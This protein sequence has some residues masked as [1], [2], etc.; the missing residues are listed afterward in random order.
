MDWNDLRYFLAVARSGSLTRAARELC[1]E[2]ATVSRR[3]GALEADLRA[4]LF[5]RGPA[6]LTLTPAGASLL[7]FVDAIAAQIAALERSV[8]GADAKV[9]GTVRLTIP[10]SGNAYFME[11]LAE[12]RGRHPELVIELLSENRTLDL[13]RGEA[14]VAVRFSDNLD[15]ELI[16]RKAGTAGWSLYAS[17]AYLARKGPLAS[18]DDLRGH[19]LIAFA[20]S[21][22]RIEGARWARS[23]DP[24]P[25]IVMRG[26]SIAAVAR[27]AAAGIGVA[28][29]PC[30]VASQE[31]GL[32]R[33]TPC[34][35]GRRDILLVAHPDLVRVARVR[36]TLD[37]LLEVFARDAARWSGVVDGGDAADARIASA[38][39]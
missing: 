37:F 23:L 25:A 38:P 9:A 22:E 1:V 39:H 2:H 16:V 20:D 17:P 35:V 26:N 15:R 10:E 27:A 24:P 19:E 30:F 8:S 5:A 21:L 29:L 14:D 11:K 3:L 12:L 6:G 13:R 7:P 31:P 32:V 33:L 36:A 4:R 18:T 28:A 34:L